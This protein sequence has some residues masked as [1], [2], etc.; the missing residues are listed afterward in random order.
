MNSVR[1]LMN[2]N[3]TIMLTTA[4]VFAVIAGVLA[5]VMLYFQASVGLPIF[6]I[7]SIGFILLQW[8]FSPS[9]VKWVSK[10]RDLQ[11]HE[12]PALHAMVERL[13]SVAGI[14]APRLLLVENPSPNA[15]AFGR[16]QSSS[17]VAVHS[18]LLQVLEK[19]EVEAVLA[20]EIGH[21]KHRDVF[22]MTLASVLPVVLYYV[23]LYFGS[24]RDDRGIGGFLV[25]FVGA[26]IA[27]FLGMLLVFWLSRKREAFADAF[28]AYATGKPQNLM[29]ALTKISYGIS[30]AKHASTSDALKAFYISSPNPSEA[31]ELAQL[32]ALAGAGDRAAFEKAVGREKSSGAMELLMSHPLTIKRLK[33]LLE[34]KKEING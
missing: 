14:P 7:I 22:V 27:Q 8:Y 25:S 4:L 9:I 23:V 30:H 26:M 19:D 10:A 33:N 20:H 15:F 1:G 34:L 17:Y 12:A 24:D 18:G 3:L 16:T 29:S 11:K 2:L 13:S 21:I 28:S 6:F 5:A 32:Y 31:L